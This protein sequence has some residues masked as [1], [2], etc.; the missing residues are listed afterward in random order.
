[1][2][3]ALEEL[4]F[5]NIPEICCLFFLFAFPLLSTAAVVFT[6]ASLYTNK[7]VSFSS[8]ISAIP[9]IFKR[10]K[11]E[12]KGKKEGD[13]G[14]KERG[15]KSEAARWVSLPPSPP[16]LTEE[17]GDLREKE[18]VAREPLR[19]VAVCASAEE[20]RA[21]R[22]RH[23]RCLHRVWSRRCRQAQS[24]P[25]CVATMKTS[26]TSFPSQ[27]VAVFGAERKRSHGGGNR[28]AP[29]CSEKL[30]PPRSY[31]HRCAL[32]HRYCWGC[33]AVT[34]LLPLETRCHCH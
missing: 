12:R 31:H 23:R 29:P 4:Q 6:V 18:S 13:R 7:A 3:L 17:R 2:D 21:R 33:A 14:R 19:R 11:K 27:I 16:L 26:P 10:K 15:E 34:E 28:E 22:R 9:K 8:T 24:P 5:L 1:M 25:G 20:D 30:P 32:H